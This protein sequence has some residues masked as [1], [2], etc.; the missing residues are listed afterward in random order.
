MVWEFQNVSH[1][2]T[3][4]MELEP[5]RIYEVKWETKQNKN[6]VPTELLI[7]G[8]CLDTENYYRL[9][10]VNLGSLSDLPIYKHITNP[11]RIRVKKSTTFGIIFR[12]YTDTNLYD[13][14]TDAIERW[15]ISWFDPFSTIEWNVKDI[16]DSYNNEYLL[17]DGDLFKN[18]K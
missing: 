2:H 6:V 1:F 11:M 18:S 4:D 9:H 5:D 17:F 7:N 3:G 12:V 13:S 16:T 10:H 8:D 15:F 14:I